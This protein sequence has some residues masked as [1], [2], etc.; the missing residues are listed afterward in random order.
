MPEC[1][2]TLAL[3]RYS[4]VK[5]KR[6]FGPGRSI[7]RF[8]INTQE[9]KSEVYG[10]EDPRA[11]ALLN[12]SFFSLFFFFCVPIISLCFLPAFSGFSALPVYL[13]LL[14]S[15]LSSLKIYIYLYIRGTRSISQVISNTIYTII[16]DSIDTFLTSLLLTCA[17]LLFRY[18]QLLLE[19]WIQIIQPRLEC[20]I[21]CIFSLTSKGK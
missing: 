5:L 21:F 11:T 14:I 8:A 1:T 20:I 10:R 9:L 17:A 13:V 12:S 16:C 15:L 7:R 6:R 19:A 18:H 4:T 3:L 2:L